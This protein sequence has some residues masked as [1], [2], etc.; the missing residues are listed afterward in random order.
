M[1]RDLAAAAST[2]AMTAGLRPATSAARTPSMVVP[3]GEQTSS[4]RTSGCL[5]VSKTIFAAPS[6][7]WAASLMAASLRSPFS[8]PASAMA[9]I[10]MY[11]NAGEL[12]ASPVMM[13]IWFSGISTARPT[14]SNTV[15]TRIVSASVSV[16]SVV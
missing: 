9:S 3:A 8:T 1:L 10:I 15:R 4:L 13:S 16:P 14:A 6:M 12:P 5:P 7:L 11:M 2:A